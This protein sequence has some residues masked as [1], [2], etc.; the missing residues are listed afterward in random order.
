MSKP[1]REIPLPRLTLARGSATPLSVQIYKGIRSLI[2]SGDLRPG[3]PLPASRILAS[4]LQLS[5]NTVVI[6]Y[7][8]LV[9]EGYL[10]GR[11]GSGTRVS[12]SLPVN[13]LIR[14]ES[15]TRS[16]LFFSKRGE[17]LSSRKTVRRL[18]IRDPKPFASGLP[19][20]SAFPAHIWTR[21]MA[22]H[23]AKHHP[24]LLAYGDP[25]GYQPLRYAICDYVQSGRGVR[26]TPEQ[27]F[28]VN[29]SQQAI[30]LC[31]RLLTDPGDTVGLEDPCYPGALIGFKAAGAN[32]LPIPVDEHG[33]DVA[34]VCASERLRLAFV[35]PS[36]QYPLGVTMS[37]S[38]RLVLLD[39]AKRNNVWILE[40]DYD[41]DFRYRNR[42]LPALQGLDTAGNTIYVGTFSKVMFPSLRLGFVVLPEGLI[43]GF[44]RAR[45]VVD[46]HSATIEQ[47]ALADFIEDGHLSRHIGRMR[48]R[49]AE[50]QGTLISAA[51]Q[52]LHGVLAIDPPEGGM[53]LVGW[54]P[55]YSNDM[56][57]AHR[58]SDHGVN[59]RA[60][61][62]CFLRRSHSPGLLLGFAAFTP[63]QIKDGVERLARA[64][65]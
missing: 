11:V 30:D 17:L 21:L 59:C 34:H 54:L 28:I 33:A 4:E 60:L 50:R 57:I 20:V 51:T 42:P 6:A 24:D 41:S 44:R 56:A 61:S 16:T 38:R 39:W 27:I 2:L 7:E 32:I 22:K 62:A 29:G 55:K 36:H 45:G 37:V 63:S 43:E 52:Y 14:R 15:K 8:Q 31:A 49:Y 13:L 47:A 26:C 48:E 46:G 35:T 12:L 25:A 1:A 64:L 9:S 53:H 19:D 23:S 5:R 10:E 40:D 3:R 58:A 65:E 18:T